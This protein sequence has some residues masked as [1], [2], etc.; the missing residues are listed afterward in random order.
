MTCSGTKVAQFTIDVSTSCANP[1]G[2]AMAQQI[3]PPSTELF[4]PDTPG[5]SHA[6]TG[7]R[8]TGSNSD[9]WLFSI[10]RRD[11]LPPHRIQFG[12]QFRDRVESQDGLGYTRVNDTSDLVDP[13]F[14]WPGGKVT[15]KP[16]SLRDLHCIP[17][18]MNGS[19]RIRVGD[20]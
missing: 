18:R 4:E 7:L 17:M 15:L 8:V 5:G 3:T 2:R 9:G 13:T 20:A 19:T 11:H 1:L 12:G 6:S 14:S 10:A 16:G